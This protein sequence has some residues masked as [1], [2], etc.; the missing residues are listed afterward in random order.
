MEHL[1]MVYNNSLKKRLLELKYSLVICYVTSIVVSVVYGYV[2]KKM[3]M[4]YI[5]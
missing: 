3:D 2:P 1:E 5:R 4:A